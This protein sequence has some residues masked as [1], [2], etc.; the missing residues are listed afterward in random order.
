MIKL[1]N[2]IW[3]LGNIP[4]R[5]DGNTYSG[6]AGC[7]E[8]YG[9]IKNKTFRYR[10]WL[11]KSEEGLNLIAAYYN[12]EYSYDSTDKSI[13]SETIFEASPKGIEAA[14]IWLNEAQENAIKTFKSGADNQ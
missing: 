9:N 13:I 6:S 1:P 12:G 3:F 14:E 8:F 11:N 4:F 5:G 7:D 10:V 2:Y